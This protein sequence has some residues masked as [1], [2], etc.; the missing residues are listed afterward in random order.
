MALQKTEDFH[1]IDCNYWKILNLRP[2]YVNNQTI[3]TLGLY[4]DSATR[5]EDINNFVKEIKIYA[6]GVH[7][8]RSEMYPNCKASGVYL[9]GAEDC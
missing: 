9:D 7:E 2:D 6:A 1:G 4:K 3:A 5:A 8:T